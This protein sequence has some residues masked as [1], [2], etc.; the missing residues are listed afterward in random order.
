MKAKPQ[1]KQ[2]MQEEQ[3]RGWRRPPI[4]GGLRSFRP[5]HE[6]ADLTPQGLCQPRT[7]SNGYLNEAARAADAT[8]A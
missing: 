2:S 7:S 5:L 6:A 4:L 1:L 8:R 3:I